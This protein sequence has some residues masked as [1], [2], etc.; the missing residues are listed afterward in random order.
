LAQPLIIF[1]IAIVL[2][3]N[4]KLGNFS[5]S[6]S[7]KD[8]HVSKAFYEKLGFEVFGGDIGQNWIIMKK[9]PTGQAD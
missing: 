2:C 5:L 8:I 9:A 4:M 7:V 1:K 6:L 3:D